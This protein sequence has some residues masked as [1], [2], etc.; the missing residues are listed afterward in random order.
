MPTIAT[1]L[2]LS[3]EE[4]QKRN[5]EYI[6]QAKSTI[7]KVVTL[8]FKEAKTEITEVD[9]KERE[10]LAIEARTKILSGETIENIAE[11]LTLNHENIQF[12]SGSGTIE[13]L[14]S[15]VTYPEVKTLSGKSLSSV[16]KTSAEK[17][18]TLSGE[19][20]KK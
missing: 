3:D 12:E 2:S 20:A 10:N 8:E 17:A 5:D 18:L 14:P 4:Q 9:K 7:G 13:T 16:I 15:I 11:K 1:D 6:T 19:T